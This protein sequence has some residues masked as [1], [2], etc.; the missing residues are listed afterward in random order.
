[1][2]EEREKCKQSENQ[3]KEMEIE[4]DLLSLKNKEAVEISDKD[5]LQIS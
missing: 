1:M 2:E 4:K 3:L 5:Q